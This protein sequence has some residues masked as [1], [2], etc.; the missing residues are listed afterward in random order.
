MKKVIYSILCCL[1]LLLASCKKKDTE[2][3]GI[4]V[5][6][7]YLSSLDSYQLNCDLTIHRESKDIKM[8]V[9][10]DYLKP[11]Y[12][13]VCFNNKSGHEQVIVKNDEGVFVL[14]PAL[15]KEFK[16]DSDWPLNSTHAYLLEGICKD[17]TA[18]KN[19]T[20]TTDGDV[21]TIESSLTDANATMAKLKFL[22]NTKQKK[23]IKAC[24][25][26][27]DNNE[28]ILVEFN[29]FTPNKTMTK[30][31]FN[32]KWI[33]D[34]KSKLNE[35]TEEDKN[36]S[37]SITVGY[38]CDGATLASSKVE[39]DSTILCYT[40]TNN[41]TI[42]VQKAGVYTSSILMDTYNSYDYLECGL[43]FRNDTVSR[44]YVEDLEVSIYSID[45]SMDDIISIA[46]DI[47]MS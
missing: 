46:S 32:T 39:N 19:A 21:V 1:V 28:K 6:T 45:L 43:I 42:V 23:P 4:K 20:F 38:V 25:L 37:V 29:E 13:K 33:M 3:D 9:S 18:D 36:T 27:K 11:S 31:L 5:A 24:V 2:K 26:D 16:F 35:K 8:V 30:D 12:Y 7:E 22:Y 40:G 15:N 17:I 14:T 41:Y 10:V 47:V 34:E 44:Y